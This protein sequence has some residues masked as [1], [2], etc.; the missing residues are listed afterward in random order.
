MEL[1]ATILIEPDRLVDISNLQPGDFFF[2]NNK[3]I[4]R[5]I[6]ILENAGI[7]IDNITVAD[8]L[9]KEGYLREIGGPG[10]IAKLISSS[11]NGF[12]TIEY[13]RIVKEKSRKR[14]AL[15]LASRI[16]KLASS[17]TFDQDLD[18]AISEL[19]GLQSK[20]IQPATRSKHS[21]TVAELLDTEFPEPKW[22]I[23]DLIPEGLT[24]IGGRP[25]VGKSWLL[26]Q[27]SIAVGSGGMFFGKRVERGI[28][29]YVAFEESD[30][31]GCRIVYAKWGCQEMRG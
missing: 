14:D 6:K 1:L 3:I 11:T 4:F 9:E 30:H 22:S 28:V 21:W 31:A 17:R 18:Q 5:A 23:P 10:Y 8:Q 13:G 20:S 19:T 26:L 16:A 15:E 25:K 7:A 29:L 24:I 27:A 12:N 2:I